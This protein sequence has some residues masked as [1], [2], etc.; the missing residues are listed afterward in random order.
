MLDKCNKCLLKNDSN[1]TNTVAGD[2][3][4]DMNN[5][6]VANSVASVTSCVFQIVLLD[7]QTLEIPINVKKTYLY[8]TISVI[9]LLCS[10]KFQTKDTIGDLYQKLCEHLELDDADIFGLAKKTSKFLELLYFNH[11]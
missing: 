4:C 11:N 10:F 7:K 6:T 8:L 2:S 5:N 3:Q 1:V 9:I